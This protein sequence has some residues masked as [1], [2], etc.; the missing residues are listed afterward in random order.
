MFG[1]GGV[2]GGEDEKI[3]CRRSITWLCPFFRS[4]VCPWSGRE[5]GR[6]TTP[7]ARSSCC[8]N[9]SYV[10]HPLQHGCHSL[11]QS[12]ATRRSSG[13]IRLSNK[14]S[15]S[16]SVHC[17][18]RGVEDNNISKIWW[19]IILLAPIWTS[20]ETPVPHNNN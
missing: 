10:T 6:S 1:G 5:R 14:C 4:S 18:R 2:G 12:P 19:K 16:L 8:A 13:K 17:L 3:R 7:L 15:S 9:F 20:S 11:S